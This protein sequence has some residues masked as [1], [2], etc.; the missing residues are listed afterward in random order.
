MTEPYL[1]RLTARLAKGLAGQS[2]DFRRRHVDYIRAC[3]N[4][5]GG[6]AGRDPASD[7][8]YTA[9]ALRGLALL[10]ALEPD[11]ADRAAGYLRQRL[12]GS[13]TAIDLFSLLYAAALVQLSAGID[14]LANAPADWPERVAT[15]LESFRHADGGYGKAAGASSGSTYHTFL[16]ALCYELLGKPLPRP[17]EIVR[18]IRSRQR[19]DGGFVEIAPMRRS[20]TNPTAAAVGV[21]Q[22]LDA[23]DNKVRAGV[24]SMLSGLQSA[25]GGLLANGRVPLADV[26]STFTGCWTLAE[27]G[28]LEHINTTAA[29]HYVQT[30]ERPEGGFHGGAWDTGFDVEYTFYGLGAI[31]LLDSI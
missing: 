23:L 28:G 31:A 10:D 15:L 30:L 13:A 26:L 27:V 17:D 9:F 25:E 6:F 21:L 14:V 19:E 1:V 12:L 5:D 24:N 3:Q 20:G 7:L 2:D 18:F 8:Y 4:D 22:I 11:I 29:L 16:V